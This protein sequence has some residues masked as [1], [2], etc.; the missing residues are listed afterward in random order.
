MPPT[1]DHGLS[2]NPNH[3]S[4]PKRG[5]S[6][7]SNTAGAAKSG[8]QRKQRKTNRNQ[9]AGTRNNA[10][11]QQQASGSLRE[12]DEVPSTARRHQGSSANH[13]KDSEL[14]GDSDV[15]DEEEEDVQTGEDSMGNAQNLT[16][17]E[18]VE[19]LKESTDRNTQLEEQLASRPTTTTQAG[20]GGQVD[21]LAN[22]GDVPDDSVPRERPM[23]IQD[24]MGLSGDKDSERCYF[25]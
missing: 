10:D 15:E 22:D 17:A 8:R 14:S 5:A 1:T 6:Q 7:I 21:P 12:P 24:A 4:G 19:L 16:K 23:S 18:L 20:P 3:P 2:S 11:E 25:R 9:S 13:D